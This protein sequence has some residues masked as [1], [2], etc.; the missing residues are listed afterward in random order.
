MLEPDPELTLGMRVRRL[1][2]GAPRDLRDRRLFHSVSLI[3]LLAWVGLGADGL[4][5]SAYGPEE[6]FHALG[7]HTYL[8]I[9]LAGL[10]A[11]TI[12]ILCTCYDRIIEAFPQ[13]GGGYV[14]ATALLGPRAGVVSGGALLIDYVL[15]ITVS[16]AAAGNALFSVLPERFQFVKLAVEIACIIGLVT[17]NI[18]G[19]KESI[20]VIAPIFLLFMLTH[21]VVIVW[22]FVG[23]AGELG[24]TLTTAKTGLDRGVTELGWMGLLLLFL[25]AYSL[26][27]GT[28]TGIEAVSN[29]VLLL[30]EPRVENGKRT[31]S[32]LGISLAVV[33]S[34]ILALYLLW[35]ITVQPG[36]TMNATLVE[37]VCSG[38]PGAAVF[39]AIT[40]A[41]EAAL[42][43]IAA[44]TGFLDGPR[45]LASLAHDSWMP[46]RFA[47]LSERLTT[48]NGIVLMGLAALAAL[49]YSRGNVS[50]LIVMYSINV[51]LTFSLSILGMARASL[52]P[53]ARKGSWKRRS[54]LFILGS[55]LCV[56]ILVITVF[57][58]FALGGWLTLV[59]TGAL[60]TLCFVIRSHYDQVSAKLME[61]DAE[62]HPTV[63][64][65]AK[66]PMRVDPEQ[67]TAAI[68]VSSY[69]G[70]GIH[71]MLTLFRAFPGHYKN[72]IFVAIGVLDS[73]EF[74]GEG[75]VE[76]L[77]KRTGEMLQKYVKL[78]NSFGIPA[79]SRFAIGTDVVDE[80]EALCMRITDEFPR[81]TF[82]AGK[83][84]FRRERWIER[85]LHN[86]T[87]FAIQ[88]RL[89]WAGRIMVVLPVRL[90]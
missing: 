66:A 10:M 84:I 5:S 82:F 38:M 19:V 44:Q 20:I 57:E 7:T 59:V 37:R 42:L 43:A 64:D 39:V 87:A 63:T 54:S 2:F 65:E 73:G 76:G 40:L 29:G 28:Y 75:A 9:P 4:S 88:R 48:H 17:L 16:I 80:A 26:G 31:M 51:F 12:L 47:A 90:R 18:R 15:T 50:F 85:I 32:Y 56:T 89:H 33:A 35:G 61:L 8:A 62:L 83:L 25:H 68:L 22:G 79:T 13:G 71:T 74:K 23:H 36:K 81:T 60:V 52:R 46:R 78:A 67:R 72:L 3:P 70:L 30:R 6:A 45:V 24:N 11:L 41:A 21:A 55:G 86:Q 1:L 69:G 49:V 14:V 58:K 34:S 53:K 27:G 77:R